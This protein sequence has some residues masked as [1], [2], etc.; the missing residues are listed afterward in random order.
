MKATCAF[1]E[2][3][4]EVSKTTIETMK[5]NAAMEADNVNIGMSSEILRINHHRLTPHIAHKREVDILDMKLQEF[6]KRMYCRLFNIY[7]FPHSYNVTESC[8]VPGDRRWGETACL[9]F[10][11]EISELTKSNRQVHGLESEELTNI[12]AALSLPGGITPQ[13]LWRAIDYC[14][15]GRVFTKTYLHSTHGPTCSAY[16]YEGEHSPLSMFNNSF[17]LPRKEDGMVHPGKHSFILRCIL[18]PD[19]F[20][21]MVG[22]FL[23]MNTQNSAGNAGAREAM[24][25]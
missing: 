17:P 25:N 1:F 18:C 7:L 3:Q 20:L 22:S 16:T 10:F 23:N 4:C 21:F 14:N 8:K 13:V 24:G 11:P 15:C 5:V 6:H 2:L 12:F 19:N 9:F